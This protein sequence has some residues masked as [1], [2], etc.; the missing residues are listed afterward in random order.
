[1][2]DLRPFSKE[3][4]KAWCDY[5]EGYVFDDID[6]LYESWNK[7]KNEEPDFDEFILEYRLNKVLNDTSL[8]TE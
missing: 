4:I 7:Y 6:D 5:I 2:I 1:M 3:E 8:Q